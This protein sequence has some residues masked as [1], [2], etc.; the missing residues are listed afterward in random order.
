MRKPI[1]LLQLA[2][3][4]M[5]AA[6]AWRLAHTSKAPLEFARD[7]STRLAWVDRAGAV[8][9]SIDLK[10]G[11]IQPRLSTDGKSVFLTRLAPGHADICTLS[12]ASHS[13]RRLTAAG[14]RS[15]FAIWGPG[16][17]RY[18]YAY[19]G[20]LLQKAA[21]SA[22]EPVR[23]GNIPHADWLHSNSVPEDWSPDGQSMV[24]AAT[25][26]NVPPGALFLLRPGTGA[27]FPLLKSKAG[28]YEARFSRDGNRIALTWART[29]RNEVYVSRAP[30]DPAA[31]PLREQSLV[32][33]SNHGGYSP[34]W[35]P[36]GELFYVDGSG[37]L[38]A[39]ARVD[40]ASPGASQPLFR[41]TS[42][43][44]PAYEYRFGGYSVDRSGE[45]FLIALSVN[46]KEKP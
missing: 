25:A 10:G 42:V 16:S 5:L 32:R 41:I 27:V 44:L 36:D 28:A 23:L 6:M 2:L 46:Y 35:G 9:E 22:P 12:L 3:A 13:V 29:G 1:F 8:L 33:V 18:V 17:D 45:R 38:M 7:A 43:G 37:E 14:K 39:A 26:D 30:L 34:E 21:G 19:K 31:L 20:Q 40:S 11:Y 4:G 24:F 15:A